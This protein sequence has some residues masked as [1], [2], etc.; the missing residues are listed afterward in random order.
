MLKK[1]AEKVSEAKKICE[2]YKTEYKKMENEKS[3]EIMEL[4]KKLEEVQDSLDKI[5]KFIRK[6]FIKEIDAK[7]LADK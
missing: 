1:D 3:K 6:I 4:T 5:P 7:M 2:L